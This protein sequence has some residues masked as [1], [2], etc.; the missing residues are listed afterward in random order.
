[1]EYGKIHDIRRINS[2]DMYTFNVDCI[3]SYELGSEEPTNLALNSANLF[4]SS[5]DE[6]LT[7]LGKV[8]PSQ[9]CC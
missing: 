5:A 3:T 7:H 4:T 1:M 6:I 8:R 9:R 2:R